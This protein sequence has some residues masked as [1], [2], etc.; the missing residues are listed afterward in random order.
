[1]KGQ[2]E[3]IENYAETKTSMSGARNT[4]YSGCKLQRNLTPFIDESSLGMSPTRVSSV[5]RRLQYGA[6]TDEKHFPFAQKPGYTW[7]V[8]VR[9]KPRDW[10]LYAVKLWP[11][12]SYEPLPKAR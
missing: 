7:G 4:M 2:A 11:R 3:R 10:H 12:C 1:M 8:G 9:T 6:C 5:G